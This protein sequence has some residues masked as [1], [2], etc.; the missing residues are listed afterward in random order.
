[1]PRE[2][3]VPVSIRPL[4]FYFY[5]ISG[6]GFRALLSYEME[7]WARRLARAQFLIPTKWAELANGAK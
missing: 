5:T 7:G 4:H 2:V 3:R 6:D 1:M